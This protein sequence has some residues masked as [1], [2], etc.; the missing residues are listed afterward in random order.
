M[1]AG[2]KICMVT[3]CY[4]PSR[5]GIE[6]SVN[7]LTEH[8]LKKGHQIHIVTSSRGLDPTNFYHEKRGNLEITRYPETHFFFDCPINPKIAAHILKCNYDVLHVHG[9]T[10][11]VSDLAIVLGKIKRR[12]VVLTYHCSPVPDY[13]RSC[14][15]FLSKLYIKIVDRLIVN[16]IDKAV[17]TTKS[18]AKANSTLKNAL[19]KAVVVPWGV[20]ASTKRTQQDV[21]N[22]KSKINV[23][24]VGQLK[25]YKGIRYL[26]KAIKLLS[27]ES[28]PL[29]LTI[30]GGGPEKRS[31]ETYA[32]IL[33]VNAN[34]TGIVSD[35]LLR[36]HYSDADIFVLPSISGREG[37]GLVI[38]EAMS[39][40]KLVIA[41]DI[42]GPN[43]I[44]KNG[45]N[46][47]L[48][49]PKDSEAIA[50]AIK[51]LVSD[52][53]LRRNISINARETA[54]GFSWGKVGEKYEG[55]YNSIIHQG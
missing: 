30:V 48:V 13:G 29:N 35:E 45:Y 19:E 14:G 44:V 12:P 17:V 27:E 26:L 21:F 50:K 11:T 2:T 55:V 10:P 40:G 41:T 31:L 43:E 34:F 20:D 42:P 46:G 47:V 23:L 1:V 8:L 54:E 25:T 39:Y 6:K 16:F 52:S 15:R 32:K 7:K 28:F 49:P 4:T 51:T 36:S 53:E 37:F 38:L 5:G 18:F 3:A 24:F 22:D 9:V 33:E